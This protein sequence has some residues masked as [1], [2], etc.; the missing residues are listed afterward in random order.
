M[1]IDASQ[2]VPPRMNSLDQYHF[3]TEGCAA[4]GTYSDNQQLD[5]Y[6]VSSDEQLLCSNQMKNHQPNRF[7]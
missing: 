4:T 5:Y 2:A 1:S 6:R 7:Q 3:A